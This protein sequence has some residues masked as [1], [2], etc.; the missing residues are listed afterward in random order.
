MSGY[1]D[2]AVDRPQGAG[3]GEDGGLILTYAVPDG[4]DVRPGHLV[5]V[6]LSKG[7][8]QGI[9]VALTETTAVENVRELL[10]L[11]DSVAV[12]A[13]DQLALG[14]WMA[15]S[16]RCSLYDALALM[17][18]PGLSQHEVVTVELT[19]A[20]RRLKGADLDRLT[21]RQAHLLGILRAG[22]GVLSTDQVRARFRDTRLGE[23]V[24]QLETRGLLTRRSALLRP[25]AQP[26]HELF[27]QLHGRGREQGA[28]S[29]E[30]G[31]KEEGSPAPRLGPV[32]EAVLDWLRAQPSSNGNGHHKGNGHTSNSSEATIP[33]LL[34]SEAPTPDSQ[35]ATPTDNPKSDWHPARAL[36]HATGAGR[37]TLR[38][39][40]RHGLL[41]VEEREVW[42]DPLA[43][44]RPPLQDPPVLTVRQGQVL[45]QIVAALHQTWRRPA[46]PT[47]SPVPTPQPP[48]PT[49]LLHGV[50]GSGK[51]EIYLRAIGQALR[52]GR[53][54]IMLVPEI[55]LT[56]Q[57]VHRFAGRFPDRVAILHSGLS[58]G[59][60]YDQWRQIRDGRLDIVIGSRSA[61]FAPLPRLGL[62]IVDEEHEWSY[63]QDESPRY[64]ARAV[65]QERAA[66]TGS[67]LILGS[68]T[69]DIAT[70]Q[71]A[72]QRV[73]VGGGG[74]GAGNGTAN[75]PPAAGRQP[76]WTLVSL[77]ARVGK[78]QSIG[79]V[80][81]TTELP[82]P[83]VR[84]VDMR[85]E[86]REGNRSIFSQAL[87]TALAHTLAAGEQAILFLNRRGS[88]TFILCR[89]CGHVPKCRYCDVPL[90]WHA[91][92]DLVLC[93]RCD[94][95]GRPPTVC[96][97]CGSRSIR[98][99]GA[100]TQRV[101][102]EMGKLFPQARVLRWDRDTAGR[103]GAHGAM[104]AAFLAHEAD[105]LVGT[106]MIAKG[107]DIPL[108]TLVGVISAD[109]G[110]HLPDFRAA[111][112]TFQLLTQVAGRA[113][114]RTAGGS[115]IVQTYSPDHYA[116][117]AAARHDYRAFYLQEIR[118]RAE[119]GYPPFSRLAKLVYS[120]HSEPA[121]Q[122]EARRMA[123]QLQELVRRHAPDTVEVIGPAPSFTHKL[124]GR[125]RWQILL[126]GEVLTPVLKALTV[127]PGWTLDVDPV[128]VL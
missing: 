31:A 70:Y 83:P 43:H 56:P 51:T 99:F 33:Y 4:L 98:R 45:E 63:K 52:L 14:R 72:T 125:Y 110:L 59:E 41:R 93:H 3:G 92:V 47:E 90:V 118:F 112:R 120:A 74:L 53:Q 65:A 24:R 9:V 48:T 79:G 68:A 94:Y 85:Q 57:M 116:I 100:G 39:L 127:P 44:E 46:V 123:A 30:N 37:Q 81:M 54:A 71:Q 32:Q 101:E 49:V 78:G 117:Q 96:P 61:G 17:L 121:T 2:V 5:L 27:V 126:R 6:P 18:P 16:Y 10:R 20:G 38:T 50:T 115:V 7:I 21:P 109:T 104:L 35:P 122:A 91:D 36:Y 67:V 113:G 128:S 111:E 86:L 105:V 62:I 73:G 66:L 29:R 103:K 69:P 25:K 42:R 76:Q 22:G 84:L 124:R 102:E 19:D 1:A 12:L 15:V 119:A 8:V 88:R 89:G 107:L 97:Q 28:G 114:R 60:R 64:H 77:P 11:V 55:A 23:T 75:N 87:Q 108:V 106:Q 13:P 82:L 40:E 34:N 80:E 95:H 58:L 26:R